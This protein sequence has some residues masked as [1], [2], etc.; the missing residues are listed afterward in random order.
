[1]RAIQRAKPKERPT[2]PKAPKAQKLTTTEKRAKAMCEDLRRYN[3]SQFTVE[4][5]KSALYGMNPSIGW[6]GGK[7][8]IAS[9]C[10]YCKLSACV[11]DAL[12]WLGETPEQNRSIGRCR[13]AGVSSV[14]SALAAIGWTLTPLARSCTSDSYRIEKAATCA[15]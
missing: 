9:G 15:P 8:S 6:G 10:G 14:Q 4:W 2:M 12:R 3:S 1:M 11:A 5:K 13:G 7:V